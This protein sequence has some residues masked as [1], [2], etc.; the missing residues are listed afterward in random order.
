MQM[1][2]RRQSL[3]KLVADQS[4]ILPARRLALDGLAAWREVLA[5]GYE[6]LVGKVVDLIAREV[7]TYHRQRGGGTGA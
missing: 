5:R 7:Q 3:E 4:M 2:E 6:G 1:P